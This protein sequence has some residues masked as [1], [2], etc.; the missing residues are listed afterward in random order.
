MGMLCFKG[1]NSATAEDIKPPKGH[2]SNQAPPQKSRVNEQDKAILDIKA[3]MRK[4]KDYYEKL[5]KDA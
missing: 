3:R 1:S 2:Y 4:L 5:S